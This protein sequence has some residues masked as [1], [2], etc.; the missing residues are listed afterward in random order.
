MTTMTN[1]LSID[2]K[3]KVI[4]IE[5]QNYINGLVDGLLRR[6]DTKE[7]KKAPENRPA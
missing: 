4:P 7:S 3:I 2:E 1:N 6:Y 5:Q